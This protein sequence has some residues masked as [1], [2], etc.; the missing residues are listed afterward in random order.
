M[1]HEQQ[2]RELGFLILSAGGTIDYMT[3]FEER[4]PERVVKARVLET[5]WRIIT[6]P[7]KNFKKFLWMF[8]VVRFRSNKLTN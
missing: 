7:K 4:A 6:K 5:L 2:L 3:G 1:E 8:G